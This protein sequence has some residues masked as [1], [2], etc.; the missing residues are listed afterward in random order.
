MIPLRAFNAH[1]HYAGLFDYV[2]RL[3]W[4]IL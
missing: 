3:L 2:P 1:P 4:R